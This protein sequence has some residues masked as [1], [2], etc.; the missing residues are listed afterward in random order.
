M[1]WIIP[2]WIATLVLAFMLGYWHRGIIK[3]IEVLEEAVKAKV[4]KQP[5]PEESVSQLID[6][7]DPIQEAI[8]ERDR[9]LKELNQ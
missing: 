2:A 5:E 9:M 8:A 1:L 6:P 3:K 7:L 4:D